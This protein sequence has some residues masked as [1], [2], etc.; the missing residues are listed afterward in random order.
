MIL[1]ILDQLSL[2]LSRY[3]NTNS[4]ALAV[5]TLLSL[6]SLF[7]CV[8]RMK[9]A[10]ISCSKLIDSASD[11]ESYKHMIS[12]KRLIFISVMAADM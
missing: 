6:L 8:F 5:M 11:D 2:Y 7:F 10:L 1:T 4:S 3:L 12:A 9:N